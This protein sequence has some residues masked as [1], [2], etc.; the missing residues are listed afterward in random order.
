MS[1]HDEQAHELLKAAERDALTL[2]I[3][4]RDPAAPLESTLFH[5]QQGV[6]KGIKAALVVKGIMFP[7]THDLLMLFDLAV[8]NALAPPVERDLCARLG[9]YAVEFRYLGVKAP[10]V[11]R[12]EAS[13]GV[14]VVLSWIREMLQ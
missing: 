4:L 3:L 10:E 7:R 2:R 11:S 6:E 12:D 5:A 14:D 13:A 9:P 8:E 1:S